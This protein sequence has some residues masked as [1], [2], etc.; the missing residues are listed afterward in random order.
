VSLIILNA[1]SQSFNVVVL[2]RE[3]D[4]AF[5]CAG[6]FTITRL[7]LDRILLESTVESIII[8]LKRYA[9]ANA[10]S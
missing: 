7:I 5:E 2:A 3:R 9:M 4:I 10:K 6:M 8:L 1:E